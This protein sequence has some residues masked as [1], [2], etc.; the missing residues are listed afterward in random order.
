M[1]DRIDIPAERAKLTHQQKL[2]ALSLRFYQGMQ[3]APKAGDYYTTSRADLELYQVVSVAGGV[4]RTRYCDPAQ[5]PAISE[6]SED[7]FV[8]AG[9]GPKRV[10]VPDFVFRDQSTPAAALGE[11]ERSQAENERLRA[12]VLGALAAI[13]TGRNEPLMAWRD[14]ARAAVQEVKAELTPAREAQDD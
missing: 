7:K 1:S 8:N 10:Y 6:W 5:S 9:F 12:L 2:E 14:H 3:W 11:L 13:D 4:V